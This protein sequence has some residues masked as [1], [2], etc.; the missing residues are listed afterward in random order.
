[1]GEDVELRC[2]CGEVHGWLRDASPRVTNRTV[3]Y[4]DDCQAFLHHLGRADLLDAH[5][6]S[7]IVQVEPASVTFDRGTEEI[8]GL[9]LGPK[10]LHRWYARCCKTP[11]GNIVKP[12]I[13]FIGLGQEIFGDLAPE[14][15]DALFGERW[16]LMGKWA[17]GGPPKDM[18][19]LSVGALGRAAGFLFRGWVRGRGW[20]SP[21]F[22]RAT[23]AP[24]YP[25]T[26]LS[27]EERDELRAFCGPHPTRRREA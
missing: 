18:K 21:F 8:V 2:R 25:F 12:A 22:D 14:R 20:P 17:V 27:K 10:C 3:C 9:R 11:L 19:G 13:P 6:G 26:V 1:M 23:N 4:C 5:G 16:A 7:D 15:R 24:R